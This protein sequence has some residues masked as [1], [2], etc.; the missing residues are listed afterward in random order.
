MINGYTLIKD[1]D[2]IEVKDPIP[3]ISWGE[4]I[5][6]SN[7]LE[8]K[9]KKFSIPQNPVREKIARD[10]VNKTNINSKNTMKPQ[11]EKV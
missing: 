6:A 3:L 11:A 8:D 7:I 2:P 9:Q 5:Q 4:L 1:P 10:L